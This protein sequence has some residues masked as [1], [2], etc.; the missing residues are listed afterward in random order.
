[1]NAPRAILFD[2]DG[3]L[4]DFDRTWGPAAGEVMRRLA[5]GD[6]AALKA[7]QQ[8]SHYL[9][10]ERRFLQTSPLIA[11]S[12][13]QY[14]PLW[15]DV[16][17]RV[18]DLDFYREVDR[19]FREEGERHLT[20]LGQPAQS[21]ARLHALGM[22]LGIATNDAERG[23]RLQA[24]RLGLDTY[25]SAIYGHDSGYGSKPAPGMVEAFCRF[26]GLPPGDIAL[27]GDTRH[28]L[29]TARAA[30]ARAILVRC[31]PGPVDAFAHEADLVVDTVEEL[32]DIIVARAEAAA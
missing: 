31:G 29:D 12:S 25:L 11:G 27:V 32:A 13:R 28:D 3:T 2:K 18:A 6:G 17:D 26:T 22:P 8:V 4:V 21:L 24:G 15:A 10:E 16:L 14:G 23:A 7:L 30:G 9:P 20:P 1:M 19:L 5:D